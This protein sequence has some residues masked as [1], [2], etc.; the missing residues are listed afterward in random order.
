MKK[1]KKIFAMLLAFTM[2]LGMTMTA[3]AA[4]PENTNTAKAIVTN[5]E[6]GA[7]VTAYQII[8]GAYG[9]NGFLGYEEVDDVELFIDEYLADSA[10]LPTS[11]EITDIATRINAGT[12][13]LTS[14]QMTQTSETV[15][16]N[17]TY[18]ADLTAG[19]WVVLVRGT[20]NVYNPMLIGVYYKV[21]GSGEDNT[22]ETD[23]VLSAKENWTL[24]TDGA[25][26]KSSE[27]PFKKTAN[28]QTQNAGGEVVYTIE[29][30]I[31][32]YSVEYKSAT[33]EIKDTFTNL[34]LKD[35]VIDVY[36]DDVK[37]ENPTGIY[38]VTG[39]TADSTTFTVSFDSSWLLAREDD[40][41][42]A[43]N[44]GKEIKIVYT[45]ILTEDAINT[46][47]GTNKAELT[48]TRNPEDNKGHKEDTEKVYSFDIDAGVTKQ[49][50]TKVE[51]GAT[52]NTTAPLAGATFKLY[53]DAACTTEY[54]N[55]STKDKLTAAGVVSDAG[56]QLHISGLNVG[57]YY[58][59]ETKAPAGYSLN[60]T[61]Y[62][63]EIEATIDAETD[64]LTAWNIKVTNMTTNEVLTNNFTV[65]NGT[66]SVSDGTI[67]ETKVMNIQ[68]IA[69]PSTGGIGTTI[70]TI[71]GCGIMIAAA[72]F[73]FVSRKKENE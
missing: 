57:T 20:V 27:V 11:E 66:A 56:G 33:F 64:E 42:T 62:K 38:S 65:S 60:D 26:A 5:V 49:V 69:L 14:V 6:K 52:E 7:T 46:V 32:D 21:D 51:E 23:G 2:V 15:T 22:L 50:I 70:F 9:T 19:Y 40:N 67:D 72:F 36:V 13:K 1:M 59:K 30:K 61:V 41:E 16:G 45:A 58:L 24:V 44:A 28:V 48:Y 3:S 34:K 12:L 31:P 29:T 73:F 17:A 18:Q 4:K 10:D 35:N 37:V 8:K 71:A 68:L 54:S 53:T 25:Y 39:N 63:I 55:T 47:A 43:V